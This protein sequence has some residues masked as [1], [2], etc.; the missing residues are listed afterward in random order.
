MNERGR[1]VPSPCA[2]EALGELG[3]GHGGRAPHFEA[4]QVEGGDFDLG[5]A[6]IQEARYFRIQDGELFPCPG[7]T[8]TEGAD[9]DA[10]EILH[11]K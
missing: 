4:V 5:A 3:E 9:I 8:V 2:A 7:D 6:E 11:L 1:P 10:I